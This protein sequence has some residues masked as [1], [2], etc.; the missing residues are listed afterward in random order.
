MG[1]AVEVA[2]EIA[3][4]DIAGVRIALAEAAHRVELCSAL[5]MGG[6]TPSAALVTGAV[7]S[8]AAAGREGFVHV[9]VRPRGGGFVYDGDELELTLAD[10]RFAREAGAGGVVVGALTDDGTVDVDAVRRI[11]D[12]AGPLEVTF[13]RAIDV[14]AE[15]SAA[16]E[17]L[18]GLGVTR[19]L[20]SGG[21]ASSI[22]GVEVLRM[23]AE[24]FAGRLQIMAGGGVR[25]DDIPALAAAGVD[26]VHLSARNSV[27]GAPSGPGGGDAA[28]DITDA[29]TV[30][31][32]VV[33]AGRARRGSE[34]SL[35][36]AEDAECDQHDL[37]D[38]PRDE[39]GRE[40]PEPVGLARRIGVRG[41]HRDQE[42]R[43]ADRR[44]DPGRRE[45]QSEAAR[46]LADA[47]DGDQ[48]ARPHHPQGRR[49]HRRHPACGAR[50]EVHRAHPDE[51]QGE[52]DPGDE[53]GDLESCHQ[54]ILS[55]SCPQADVTR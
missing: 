4:Q 24:S 53:L 12:E 29:A 40:H 5:G 18:A 19:V 39:R 42:H 10:V 3:V 28:F 34:R 7:A 54:P 47:R 22:D 36:R 37:Q 8:A 50:E 27:G 31:R 33:A 35:Q 2:V 45:Q 43:Q 17:V 21:A 23:L 14:V 49:D 51:H 44:R 20:T 11:V 52:E 1:T 16:A 32:A 26:A 9:L 46:Q 55:C 13:H 25:V 38:R 41:E 6:L 15:P 30:H 48:D